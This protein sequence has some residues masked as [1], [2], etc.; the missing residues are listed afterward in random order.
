M[1]YLTFVRFF[2]GV[3]P[4]VRG[5]FVLGVERLQLP[6]AVL[7]RFL[8]RNFVLKNKKVTMWLYLPQTRSVLASLL[9]RLYVRLRDV[10]HQLP[11]R[12]QLYSAV[13]PQAHVVAGVG[14]HGGRGRGVANG[15]AVGGL[16]ASVA[17]HVGGSGRHLRVRG[18]QT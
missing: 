6:R 18:S 4:H 3:H 2:F 17:Q 9:C 12:L 5:Q 16:G 11:L 7:K 1:S 13:H 15:R 14:Q 10:L 8:L